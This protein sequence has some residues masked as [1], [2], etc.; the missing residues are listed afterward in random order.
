[1]THV[2]TDKYSCVGV[3]V[4]GV[5]G[6]EGG[7]VF[8]DTHTKCASLNDACGYGQIQLRVWVCGWWGGLLTHTLSVAV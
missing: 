6:G 2:V 3:S 7:G 4:C 8:T 5:V 1:M